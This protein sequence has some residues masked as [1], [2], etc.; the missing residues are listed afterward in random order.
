MK[1]LKQN[2]L[3][4]ST[5]DIGF[6]KAINENAEELGTNKIA[7][8][9]EVEIE[10][11]VNVN[12]ESVTPH[13]MKAILNQQI[14]A[15][16]SD[17]EITFKTPGEPV[18]VYVDSNKIGPVETQ[19]LDGM[20][21]L[22]NKNMDGSAITGINLSLVEDLREG[23]ANV[24][25]N[26]VI[27]TLSFTGTS[28]DVI[29]SLDETGDYSSFIV[30]SNNLKVNTTPLTSKTYN[31]T[32]KATSG[33]DIES[34]N[35]EIEVLEA[36]PKITDITLDKTPGLREDESNVNTGATVATL[37]TVGGTQP[38]TY[39]IGGTDASSF[40][41][42]ENK[43]NV[44]SNPLT[45]KTYNITITSTDKNSKT[46]TV[47]DTIVVQAAYPEITSFT[48]SPKSSLIHGNSNVQADAIVATMSVEG[49]S[50]PITYSLREDASN[51]IDNSSFKVDGANLKVNTTPLVTKNY[52]VALR[53]TDVHGKTKD[54]N[55]IIEVS[56]PEIT[57]LTITPVNSLTAP[58]AADTVVAN[59]STQGGISPYTYSLKA[60]TGDNAEFKI[61]NN[62]V[63]NISSIDSE[64]TKSITVIVTDVNNKTKEQTAQITVNAAG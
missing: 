4:E 33:E 50:N 22:Y 6:V 40:V 45:A 8:I 10:D 41:I 26:A 13:R 49:G 24:N 17:S 52:K 39:T 56:A 30:E 23:E 58:V 63:K 11:G 31:I 42:A 7:L 36:Y 53:A 32:I 35:F 19:V 20:V 15:S 51:G 44:K 12:V 60:S 46:K 61:E 27:G 16:G 25:A 3:E 1:K 55:T 59:L 43:L 54:Q 14:T 5:T 57:T 29:Y 28:S 48:I 37:T 21:Q 47:S 2:N 18:Q 34:K 38:F 62:T 64:A 9:R